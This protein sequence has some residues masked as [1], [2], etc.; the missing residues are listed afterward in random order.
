MFKGNNDFYPTPNS[1]IEKMLD[2]I[3]LREVTSLLEPSVGKGNIVDYITSQKDRW[4][5]RKYNIDIDCIEI[6]ENLRHICRGKGYKVV[7]DN[8]LT[9]NTYK[10]Y[11]L[12][13][14]NF[15]FS[16]GEHHLRKALDMLESSGGQLSC[17]VNAE[18]IRNPYTN[19]RKSIINTLNYHNASIEY[20]ENE[21]IEAERKT[22]VEIA[23]IKCKIERKEV[24]SIL[25]EELKLAQVQ[26][27]QSFRNQSLITNDFIKAIIIQY[28]FECKAGIT[29]INE[30]KKLQAFTSSE[31]KK[32]DS[33][34]QLRIASSR[35]AYGQ[36]NENILVND[37]LKKLR[38]KYWSALLNNKDFTKLF[39]SNLKQDFY[40]R[41]DELS[42]YDFTEFNINQITKQLNEQVITGVEQTILAL[43]DDLSNKY[44][45]DSGSNIHYFNGWKT[46]KSWKINKKVIIRLNGYGTWNDRFDPTHYQCIDRL[47]DIEKVFNY[48]NTGKTEELTLREILKQAEENNQTKGIITKFFKVDFYRKG[49]CHLTFLDE[50]LL[51]KFNIFGSQKRGFL[52]PSYGK[53]SYKDM[54]K[55]EQQVV[56]EFE[57]EKEYNKVITKKDYYIY[58]PSSVLM[59]T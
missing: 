30:H 45:L 58:N 41:L 37:Y 2:G 35:D 31:F 15:P 21:F 52:P 59:L 1:L 19:V 40:N 17:I 38:Y 26:E 12:I 33:I 18:T 32:E 44:S 49:S 4:G 28:N 10:R 36:V 47:L 11:S 43:F 14:A 57:G 39:T 56:D 34:L 48:L 16:D 20:L 46:T 6:D 7:H 8:F 9:Y 42:D 54:T 27:E 3:S 55:E 53:K 22:N 25:L 23:L 5:H 24:G 50:D 29:L 13:L 51:K